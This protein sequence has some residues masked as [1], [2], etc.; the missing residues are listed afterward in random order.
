MYN[1]L[2]KEGRLMIAG[3]IEEQPDPE[4]G[5]PEVPRPSREETMSF[6][7][8]TTEGVGYNIEC[9]PCRLKGRKYL[10]IGETSRSSYQRGKEHL[11]DIE[12]NKKTHPINIHFKEVHNGEIQH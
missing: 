7:K 2:T 12:S 8:C 6:P 5:K 11:N 3:E 10:Y 4:P 9:W 1:L